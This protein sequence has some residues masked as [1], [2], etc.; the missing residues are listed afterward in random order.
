MAVLEMSAAFA[1]RRAVFPALR[2]NISRHFSTGG[3]VL[4]RMEYETLAV[5][6]PRQWV[7][8]VRLNR[9]EKRNAMNQTFWKEMVEC[10]QTL[11]EDSSCRVVLLTGEGKN[12]TS[13]LDLVDFAPMFS[14]FQSLNTDIARTT[15]LIRRMVQP[16]QNSFTA[17]EKCMKPVIA[18]IHSACIGGGV[19]MITSCDIR[20][21]SHDAWFQVKEVDLGMAA[22]VGTLQRLPKVVGNDS[23]IRDV[24]Y[25]ARKITA[26]EALTFGLVSNVYGDKEDMLSNALKMAED[27]ASKSPV[28]VQGSKV[29][30]NYSR[31]HSV[32]EGLDFAVG[33]NS[34]M[35]QSEDVSKAVMSSIQKEKPVFS[36][37]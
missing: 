28:A 33:W 29:N 19:D 13:G 25:T 37:L 31:D 10:F 8:E 2:G 1:V 20:L 22:D 14:Q 3:Q 16:M 15:L 35:L 9:P 21:C 34:T 27:I 17:I 5:T 24:V 32:E 7:T 23:W 6:Q 26:E 4:N 18:C 36:K 11:S 12:F 30:L